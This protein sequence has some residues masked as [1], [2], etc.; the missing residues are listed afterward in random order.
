MKVVSQLYSTAGKLQL[1]RQMLG[2]P[3]S[4]L[5]K[6]ISFSIISVDFK[7]ILILNARRKMA[8]KNNIKAEFFKLSQ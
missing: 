3:N 5:L 4:Q 8:F 7:Q 2:P 6:F 1:I